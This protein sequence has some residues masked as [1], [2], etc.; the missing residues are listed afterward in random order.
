MPDPGQRDLAYHLTLCSLYIYIYIYI[1]IYMYTVLGITVSGRY[2]DG[3]TYIS[4]II[5]VYG[6][7]MFQ[8]YVHGIVAV[9]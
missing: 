5:F 4:S 2:T 3:I 7:L 1:P 6:L 9:V 8:C